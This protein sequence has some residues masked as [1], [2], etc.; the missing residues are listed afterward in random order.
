MILLINCSVLK[1]GKTGPAREVYTGPLVQLGIRFAEMKG[2]RPLILSGRYGIITPETIVESYDHKLKKPYAGPW[3]AEEGFWLGSFEYFA[4]APEH[5]KRLLPH[6]WSYGQQKGYLNRI[7][8][9]E[10]YRP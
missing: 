8:R 2:W 5:I 7:V 4:N 1:S 10:R 3:P 9:P 6:E